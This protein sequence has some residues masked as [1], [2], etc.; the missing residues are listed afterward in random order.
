MDIVFLIAA[1][2]LWGAVAT[3]A[4]GCARLQHH[5]VAP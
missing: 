4:L 3:L 1:A 2:A 5:R